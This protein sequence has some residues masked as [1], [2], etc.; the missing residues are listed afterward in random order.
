MSARIVGQ[1]L[2]K[3]LAWPLATPHAHT[4]L[5][6]RS[7]TATFVWL[8]PFGPFCV[9]GPVARSVVHVDAD[10][11]NPPPNVQSSKR[12]DG[13]EV[14][15]P[16]PEPPRNR[17]EQPPPPRRHGR[18][19]RNE[20]T[21][22]SSEP[23]RPGRAPPMPPP[24][25]G[26]AH[27][28]A[29]GTAPGTFN[30]TGHQWR[31]EFFKTLWRE[32]PTQP[33]DFATGD[34]PRLPSSGLTANRR[35]LPVPLQ[36]PRAA[37]SGGAQRSKARERLHRLQQQVDAERKEQ[38]E[39]DRERRLHNGRMREELAALKAQAWD[40]VRSRRM[41]MDPTRKSVEAIETQKQLAQRSNGEMPE[42][43]RCWAKHH[44][45]LSYLTG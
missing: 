28:R 17:P 32:F 22:G 6:L 21:S 25:R 19:P 18:P 27:S 3:F 24:R 10:A 31:A 33:F 15:E 1:G 42:A 16:P 30:A 35:R 8:L 44:P 23:S 26:S 11:A 7:I 38:D 40:N 12:A 14:P 13:G 37:S 34:P 20:R 9:F 45:T 39:A 29:G 5:R 41:L 36:P 43:F 4:P 2:W